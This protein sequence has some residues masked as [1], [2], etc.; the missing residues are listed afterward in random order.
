MALITSRRLLAGAG[1]VALVAAGAGFRA[2]DGE[3]SATAAQSAPAA[4]PPAI[5]VSVA[6]VTPQTVTTWQEFSG[7]LEAVESVELRSRVPGAILAANFRDGTLVKKGDLLVSID[8]APFE[9][10]V[11]QA[12]A[13]VA[14][15]EARVALAKLELDRGRKLIAS[16]TV[17]QSDLDQRL[18]AYDEANANLQAAQAALQSAEL[19]LGYTSIR[20]PISGRVGALQITSGNLVAAGAGSPVL[21]TI[22]SV[23]PIYASFDVDEQVVGK[24][25]AQ[26]RASQSGGAGVGDIPVV[27]D[28]GTGNAP[29]RGHLQFIDNHVD[30]GS[31]T[32]H[33][34]AVFDNPDG[35]LLPGQFVR[36]R[37]GQPKPE[38]QLLISE[39][40]VGTDQDKKF[41]F[42]VDAQDKLAYRQVELGAWVKGLRIVT[43]GL[44]AGDRIVVDGLQ[45]VRPGALVDPQPTKMA[46]LDAG[47]GATEVAEQ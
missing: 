13:E 30:T 18:T 27:I 40:A 9:A 39:R 6:T 25:L 42:V 3:F 33:V 4:A 28:A 34:R 5:P 29:I 16:N 20:A 36:V 11:A 2:F 8:P 19:D 15:A 12:K 21:T 24:A 35:R 47:A 41:V 14:A 17:S 37:I 44:Q 32:V 46:A 10:S 1:L 22:V 23:D 26:E 31:G 7:R 45:R 38:P 43:S